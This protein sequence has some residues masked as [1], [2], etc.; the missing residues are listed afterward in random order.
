MYIRNRDVVAVK[1]YN[2]GTYEDIACLW[3]YSSTLVRFF[4]EGFP[5]EYSA[6]AL[7]YEDGD[8]Y[9]YMECGGGDRYCTGA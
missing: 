9:R 3:F 5:S 2:E 1:E 8:S 6:N 4:R 7:V